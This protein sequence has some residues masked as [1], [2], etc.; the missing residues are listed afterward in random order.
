MPAKKITCDRKA[1]ID[2]ANGDLLIVEK[3]VIKALGDA[4]SE[5]F[6]AHR[7]GERVYLTVDGVIV[8]TIQNYKE[9]RISD[10]DR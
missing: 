4:A 5:A 7:K 1:F 8:S 3:G 10:T 9:E 2:C 6:E